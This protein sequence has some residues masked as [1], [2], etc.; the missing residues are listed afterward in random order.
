MS[1]NAVQPTTDL[2]SPDVP[3]DQ[4]CPLRN[5]LSLSYTRCGLARKLPPLSSLTRE[6]CSITGSRRD[7]RTSQAGPHYSAEG[8]ERLGQGCRGKRESDGRGK[9]GTGAEGRGSE[10]EWIYLVPLWLSL[11]FI[12][13]FQ[14]GRCGTCPT[15]TPT[16]SHSF[17]TCMTYRAVL[18]SSAMPSTPSV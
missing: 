16:A 10:C 12:I 7:P 1:E 11:C 18:R 15:L 8:H 2:L 5:A 4:V 17:N 13:P 3:F 9:E 6:L 14:K